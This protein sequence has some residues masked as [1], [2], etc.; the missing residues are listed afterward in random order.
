[1]KKNL[2]ALLGFVFIFYVQ[3]QESDVSIKL[4]QITS[5]ETNTKT[6]EYITKK[7]TFQDGKLASI[8]TS[9]IIQ[10]FFYNSNGY[11]ERTVRENEMSGWKEVATYEYDNRHNLIKYV[12]EYEEGG[13]SVTKTIT[14]KYDGN[15]IR[16]IT[17]KSNSPLKFV[18]W[19]DYTLEKLIQ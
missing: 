12:N 15:K 8:K 19:I 4:K 17:K 6:G 5:I 16:A 13:K 11:L 3:A 18:Q 7:Y 2:L 10:S 14:Y 9:D 1:M